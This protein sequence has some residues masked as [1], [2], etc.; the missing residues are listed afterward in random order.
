MLWGKQKRIAVVVTAA[1]I[2]LCGCG[3]GEESRDS[4]SMTQNVE[5]VPGERLLLDSAMAESLASE[6]VDEEGGWTGKG[7][8]YRIKDS[9]L[10]MGVFHL[11]F[12][13]DEFY[14]Q[15]IEFETEKTYMQVFR[16]EEVLYKNK[17]ISTI[18]CSDQGI[19]VLEEIS[20]V[21]GGLSVLTLVLLDYDGKEIARQDITQYGEGFGIADMKTDG[22][23]TLFLLFWEGVVLFSPQGVY[24]TSIPLDAPGEKLVLGGDGQMYA[25]TGGHTEPGVM[26]GSGAMLGSGETQESG[27]SRKS[28]EMEGIEAAEETSVLYRLDEEKRE[29]RPAAEYRGYLICDGTEDWLYTL[30][31]HEGLYGVKEPEAESF[32]IAIWSELGVYL[33]G[34]RDVTAMAGGKYLLEAQPRQRLYL[35]MEPADPS[36]MK[37]KT[38]LTMACVNP[39]SSFTI[40]A[41][42]FNAASSQYAVRFVDYTEKGK[43][44]TKE[45]IERL[46]MDIIAGNYPDMLDLEG[47]PGRYYADKGLLTDLYDYMD[48]DPDICREDFVALDKLETDGKLYYAGNRFS[49]ETAVGLYSRFGQ[50]SG[51]SLEEY[52]EMQEQTHGEMMYN[53]TKE[54]FLRSIVLRYAVENVDWEAGTCCFDTQEFIEILNTVNQIREGPQPPDDKGDDEPLRTQLL[55]GNKVAVLCKIGNINMIATL[56]M[57]IGER[58]SLIGRPTMDGEGGT[59]LTFDNLMSICSMGNQ[60]GS[61]EFMKFVLTEGLDGEFM[62]L[63]SN[64][65][66][67]E[68]QLEKAVKYYEN[69][70]AE[71]PFDEGDKQMIYQL[72][73]QGVYYGNASQN[74]L[75]IVM[76][77]AAAFLA[78][79]KDAG[80]TAGVIQSR[81]SIL[82]A[83][84]GK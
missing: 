67:L 79:A 70:E 54:S 77:E 23:G 12:Y 3:K 57:V 62:G 11:D 15:R 68:G 39:Y 18:A 71:A 80:E 35:I 51:W 84:S 27:E 30:A 19:W 65:R 48:S 2:A 45:A 26:Q 73:D 4:V 37:V 72:I 69:G 58:L 7:G 20:D 34:L 42:D 44:D 64:R 43:Y 56:E 10:G 41:A 21:N 53:V 31:D 28:G 13:Q 5:A 60:E 50:A 16:G 22:E 74:V 25:V 49:I 8:C 17:D 47:L 78:G 52:L 40:S 29:A 32:P 24:L 61:W 66:L 14:S 9:G 83:E 59:L 36:E 76:E 1:V 46:N 81:V 63:A 6:L 38:M 55:E 82:A 75:D 33:E